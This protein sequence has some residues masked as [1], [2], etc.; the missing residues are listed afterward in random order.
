MA[1]LYYLQGRYTEAEPLYLQA[2]EIFEERLEV[3]HPYAV[4]CRENLANLRDRLSPPQ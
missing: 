1:K 4:K 2:L 3:N